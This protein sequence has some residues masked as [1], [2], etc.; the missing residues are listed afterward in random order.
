[1]NTL[2]Q[3]MDQFGEVNQDTGEVEIN[4]TK[5]LKSFVERGVNILKEIDVLK[6]DYKEL[7][8]EADGLNYDKAELKNLVKHAYKNTLQDEIEKLEAIQV[9]LDNLFGGEDD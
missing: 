4:R 6:Q 1:M 2:E 9:K 3:R 7:I 8:E 5:E